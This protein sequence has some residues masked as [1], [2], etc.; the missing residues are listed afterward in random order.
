MINVKDLRKT[1]GEVVAVDDVSF[2]AKKGGIVGFIGPSGAG[3][4]TSLR[5]LSCFIEPDRGSAASR[6]STPGPSRTRCAALWGTC[7]KNAPSTG[8]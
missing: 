2:E 7:P 6:A 4:T 8:R 5:M 1:Y 3:K